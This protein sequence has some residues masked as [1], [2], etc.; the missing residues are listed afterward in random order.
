MNIGKN[1]VDQKR[2]PVFADNLAKKTAIFATILYISLE[3]YNKKRGARICRKFG[4]ENCLFR[5]WVKTKCLVKP[6]TD[7]LLV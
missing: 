3:S 6:K 1:R 5:T 7:F 2:G 4:K